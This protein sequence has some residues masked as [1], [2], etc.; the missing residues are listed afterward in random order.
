[1][2]HV[3]GFRGFRFD[4]AKVG[5]LD[6]VITPPYDVILPSERRMLAE[7]NRYSMVHLIL[8]EASDGRNRYDAA[9]QLLRLWIAEGAL[10]QDDAESVYVLEQT[11]TDAEGATRM[12]RAFLG[13]AKLPEPGEKT[14]LGHERTFSHALDDRYHLI[15]A[16][17]ANLDPVF[18]L[19]AD[20]EN[21]LRAFLDQTQGRPPDAVAHTFDGVTQRVWRVAYDPDAMAFFEGKRLYIA[22]GH[23]RFHT[24]C[25]YRDTMREQNHGSGLRAY[26]YAMM[27]FVSLSDP[28]LAIE[29]THRLIRLPGDFQ[30]GRV[31]AELERWFEVARVEQG[32]MEQ[33]ASAPGCVLG[34][35]VQGDGAYLLTLRAVGRA[36]MM[37]ADRGPAWRDLDVAVLHRCIVERILGMSADAE[38]VYERDA[39]KVMAAVDRGEFGL[40]FLLKATR[41]DQIQACAEA[42]EPMPHKSTYFFPKLPSGAAIHLLE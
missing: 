11:F 21:R 30:R 31:F 16:T 34:M 6:H 9:A 2:L 20:P 12:R 28:G 39:A 25:V 18:V 1:M 8:P 10:T 13:A 27:G 42:G 29:P 35:A 38:F 23:H 32:L 14:I 4:A 26:D 22:D 19:Y 15:E 33:V 24:A 3:K 40:G 36:E 17:R 37:G 5:V 7:Q 41:A